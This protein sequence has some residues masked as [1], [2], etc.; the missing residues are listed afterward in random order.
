MRTLIGTLL[1]GGFLLASPAL[2][3]QHPWVASCVYAG[4][5][6][7]GSPAAYGQASQRHYKGLHA[8][9]GS[10]SSVRLRAPVAP[11]TETFHGISAMP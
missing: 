5:C 8:A 10:A 6:N 9:R 3:Q 2:A 11:P 4:N 7:T 1:A